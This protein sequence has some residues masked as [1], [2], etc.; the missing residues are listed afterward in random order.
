M[1]S[2][3][4]YVNAPIFGLIG[5]MFLLSRMGSWISTLAATV[6][7]YRGGDSD[8]PPR[9]PLL[10]AFPLA[11]VLHS[12]PW[13]LAIAAYLSYY[14]LSRP[15]APWWLWFFGGVCVAPILAAVL[16]L[17]A[18]RKARKVGDRTKVST[19]VQREPHAGRGAEFN[20]PH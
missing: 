4:A 7:S 8:A 15:Y 18:R 17:A 3:L 6:K 13:M 14:V 5:G 9:R 20:E 12:G 2:L 19:E 11:A 16:L 10:W 1:D